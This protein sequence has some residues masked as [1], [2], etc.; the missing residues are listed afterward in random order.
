MVWDEEIKIVGFSSDTGGHYFI[1]ALGKAY[2][3]RCSCDATVLAITQLKKRNYETTVRELYELIRDAEEQ[4][5]NAEDYFEFLNEI[6]RLAD[7]ID[8][9]YIDVCDE[10]IIDLDREKQLELF[11]EFS[12]KSV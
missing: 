4:V 8:I 6:Q 10:E 2:Y 7:E 5:K 3:I 11:R 12:S 1:T 9:D